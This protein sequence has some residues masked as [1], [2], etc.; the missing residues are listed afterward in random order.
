MARVAPEDP[1]AGLADQDLLVKEFPELELLDTKEM[2]AED[3][4]QIAL[5]A[6]APAWR[7][8]ASPNPA[9]LGAPGVLPVSFW[10]PAMGSRVPT[11]RPAM[12]CP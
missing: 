5:E 12:A 10:R 3:L 1:Y 11:C 4:T 7:W 2:T 8:K 6:E 9:V